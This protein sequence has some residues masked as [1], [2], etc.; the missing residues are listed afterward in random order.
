MHN[1]SGF[2]FDIFVIGST[3]EGIAAAEKAASYGLKVGLVDNSSIPTSNAT[4]HISLQSI[5]GPKRVI[6]FISQLADLRQDQK[7]CGFGDSTSQE[8][9]WDQLCHS[10]QQYSLNH[11]NNIEQSLKNK[12]IQLYH[13]SAQLLGPH[14]V[15]LTSSDHQKTTI[16]SANIII[17]TGSLL[18]NSELQITQNLTQDV[19]QLFDLHKHPGKCL[20]VGQNASSLEYAGF[21]RGL[22]CEVDLI[23]Q[24]QPASNLDQEI[25]QKLTKFMTAYSGIYFNKGQISKIEQKDS[26]KIVCWTNE[27]GTELSNIY[28]T[29]FTVSEGIANSLSLGLEQIGVTL[30]ANNQIQVNE[31]FQTNIDSIF[32]IGSVSSANYGFSGISVKQSLELINSLARKQWRNINLTHVPIVLLTPLEYGFCGV[33]EAQAIT[34]FG[35]SDVDIYYSSFKPLEWNFNER[36]KTNSCFTKVILQNKTNQIIGIH[37]LG[38]NATEVIQGFAITVQLGLG[39][40]SLTETVAIHPTTAEEI[41]NLKLNKRTNDPADQEE[42]GC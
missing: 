37:Y 36:R 13:G 21:L 30:N 22:G 2:Q 18:T 42:G 35:D 40:S 4:D 34:L 12:H 38:P 20:L 41:V 39:L 26:G 11:C 8:L 6:H 29:I 15:E 16:A 27:E 17:A 7:E 31:H 1:N 9:N 5:D 32:A 24:Q 25:I 3:V 19:S 23:H 28:E 33:S 14:S 10:F